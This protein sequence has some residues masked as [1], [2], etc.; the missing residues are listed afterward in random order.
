MA[1]H[2]PGSRDCAEDSV[3][4]ALPWF[5][6]DKLP[7]ILFDPVTLRRLAD[8]QAMNA[9]SPQAVAHTRVLNRLLARK[10]TSIVVIGGSMVA[11]QGC[12]R[13]P[14]TS[15]EP[16]Q[17]AECSYA[18]RFVGWLRRAF[19]IP[20]QMLW[21]SNRAAGGTDTGGGLP[22]LPLL[23][24]A[25]G[26]A[27]D[28][29]IV[30]YSANDWINEALRHSENR[31]ARSVSRSPSAAATEV[32]LRFMLENQP[33]T[34]LLLVEAECHSMVAKVA[35]ERVAQ[36]YGVPFVSYADMLR[37]TFT[38]ESGPSGHKACRRSGTHWHSWHS[39][40]HPTATTHQYI[41]DGLSAWWWRFANNCAVVGHHGTRLTTDVSTSFVTEPDLR[42]R[43]GI[44]KPL[45]VYDARD[46]YTRFGAVVPH[47]DA[48]ALGDSLGALKP[49]PDPKFEA[50]WGF[51]VVQARSCDCPCHIPCGGSLY[52]HTSATIPIIG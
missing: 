44:C 26:H 4:K 32:L 13:K 29:L 17:L 2:V 50:Q 21:F 18:S 5:F 37:P 40:L 34:A 8:A 39:L 38:Y 9:A 22:Q 31:S 12:T 28:L 49:V 25:G 42:Q 24:D 36:H 41:S 11:G 48:S 27:A 3:S 35:H 19:G 52:V 15:S 45:S 16:K 14:Y 1:K 51:R 43:F 46:L 20:D 47:I 10:H 33:Q 7:H 23:I 6:D 30:D